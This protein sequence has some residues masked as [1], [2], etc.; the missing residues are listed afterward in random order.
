MASKKAG[1]SKK[2]GKSVIS[3]AVET[4]RG[5]ASSIGSSVSSYL[6]TGGGGTS[7]GGTSSGGGNP[8]VAT[9]GG[10]NQ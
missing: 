1:G 7:G 2:G 3:R 10:K 5:T 6:P 9:N 4:I 8:D